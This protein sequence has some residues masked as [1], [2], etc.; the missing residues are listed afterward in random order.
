M[1]SEQLRRIS[2]F[3]RAGVAKIQKSSSWKNQ[4]KARGLS[5]CKTFISSISLILELAGSDLVQT[6]LNPPQALW[7]WLFLSGVCVV[8]ENKEKEPFSCN[9]NNWQDLIWV[10]FCKNRRFSGFSSFSGTLIRFSIKI[11]DSGF[12]FHKISMSGI[13]EA[14]AETSLM[15]R[16][17]GS[18]FVKRGALF[19]SCTQSS[20][21]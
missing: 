9:D 6:L 14:T 16:L 19:G 12:D 8:F 4:Q 13:V 3:V 20:Q 15:L 17:Y 7:H 11:D 5:S 1:F 2:C 18:G 10:G 21:K